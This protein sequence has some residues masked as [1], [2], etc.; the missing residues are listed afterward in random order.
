MPGICPASV[1][2][3]NIRREPNTRYEW[4]TYMTKKRWKRV[5]ALIMALVLTVGA[6]IP[7][8]VYANA[9][10]TDADAAVDSDSLAD[11]EPEPVLYDK[12]VGTD[13]EP[14]KIVE[15]AEIVEPSEEESRESGGRQQEKEDGDSGEEEPALNEEE[16]APTE[17]GKVVPLSDGEPEMFSAGDTMTIQTASAPVLMAAGAPDSMAVSCSGYAKYCGHSMGIKYISEPGAYNS[18]LVYCLELSKNTTDGA[19]GAS[20]AGS[21]I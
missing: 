15:P 5:M 12:T 20:G 2:A 13:V 10:G 16:T 1:P 3:G 18:H 6:A 4:R 19:V 11:V 14:A 8:A 21:S 17:D 7:T 9:D